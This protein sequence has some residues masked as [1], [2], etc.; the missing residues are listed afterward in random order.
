METLEL[1]A[2]ALGLAALSGINLYLTVFATS[3]A[4]NLGWLHLSPE[5]QQLQVLADPMILFIS[6]LGYFAEFFAD[7]IPGIDSLWDTIHTAL[8]PLGAAFLAITVL[9]QTDPAIQV[10]A[11]LLCTGVAFSTHV[12]KAGL[13]AVVN[14]SPEPVS[15]AVVSVTEDVAVAGGLGVVYSYPLAALAGVILFMAGFI[16]LAPRLFRHLRATIFFTAKR[17]FPEDLDKK[18]T[19]AELPSK[20]QEHIKKIVREKENDRLAWIV[21]CFTGKGCGRI[22]VN[23]KAWLISLEP[24][25]RVA[26]IIKGREPILLYAEN[27][28]VSRRKRFLYN[29]FILLDSASAETIS[30]RVP[31]SDSAA[32]ELEK[33]LQAMGKSSHKDG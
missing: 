27:I 11:V 9:G 24:S 26:F 30:F 22:G 31:R 17:L 13:R 2:T 8:R 32:D 10:A 21:S 7:K 18:R 14:T 6:G 33:R 3:L 1:L 12:T 28:E 20:V 4:L 19:V 23:R 29:E 15:N 25:C 5:L 16:Y